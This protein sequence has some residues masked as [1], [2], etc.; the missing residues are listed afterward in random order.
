MEKEYNDIKIDF[1]D[2]AKIYPMETILQW[3]L[4]LD[5]Q[6]LEELKNYKYAFINSIK[7][8]ESSL[9]EYRF[10]LFPTN[11][12]Q[13]FYLEVELEEILPEV[14]KNVLQALKK[15]PID[16]L[17]STGICMSIKR[18]YFGVFFSVKDNFNPENIVRIKEELAQIK[19]ILSI[20]IKEILCHG[21]CS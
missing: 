3:D 7:N 19:K 5:C 21:C 6:T 4:P 12:S 15:Y 13:G 8:T 9:T 11:N 20:S 2:L 17:N 14:L 10:K 16:L 1:E 18:C